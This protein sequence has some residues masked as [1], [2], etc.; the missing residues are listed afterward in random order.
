[1]SYNKTIYGKGLYRRKWYKFYGA[2]GLKSQQSFSS[3][4]E[5]DRLYFL[6]ILSLSL[7]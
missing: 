7:I 2:L 1:L 6:H 4:G 5:P 3:R